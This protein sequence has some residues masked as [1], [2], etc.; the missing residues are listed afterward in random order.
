MM[1]FCCI[2]I[3]L[4]YSARQ[5]ILFFI[6][7]LFPVYQELIKSWASYCVVR[8]PLCICIC[9]KLKKNIINSHMVQR[10]ETVLICNLQGNKTC[11]CL[12]AGHS[13]VK[14]V[15]WTIWGEE[16]QVVVCRSQ[17]QRYYWLRR[18][19]NKII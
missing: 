6:L 10:N 12:Y 4:N 1:V 17:T 7:K 15:L 14:C 19:F 5:I 9:H 13:K 11:M 18:I 8:D 16:R 2:A 3:R